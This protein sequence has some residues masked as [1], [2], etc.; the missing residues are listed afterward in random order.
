VKHQSPDRTSSHRIKDWHGAQRKIECGA[1]TR[2]ARRG[3]PAEEPPRLSSTTQYILQGSGQALITMFM[4]SCQRV[5]RRMPV[6]GY[7]FCYT[8]RGPCGLF[9]PICTFPSCLVPLMLHYVSTITNGWLMQSC[10]TQVVV[11]EF[12]RE[13]YCC[14]PGQ[15]LNDAGSLMIKCICHLQQ[16]PRSSWCCSDRLDCLCRN[17]TVGLCPDGHGVVWHQV[18]IYIVMRD[19]CE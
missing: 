19:I 12:T 11:G 8:S 1:I 4:S 9:T 2:L 18:S 14:R 5:S 16:H 10:T 7:P 17:P 15:G 3:R 6:A 13:A